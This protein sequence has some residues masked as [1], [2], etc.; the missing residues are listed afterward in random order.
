MTVQRRD[1]Q[2]TNTGRRTL[3]HVNTHTRVDKVVSAVG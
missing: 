1:A 2:H 3:E